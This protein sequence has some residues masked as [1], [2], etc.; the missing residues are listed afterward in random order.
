[1][2]SIDLMVAVNEQ[3]NGQKKN[4]VNASACNANWYIVHVTVLI[5]IT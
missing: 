2:V 4:E 3:Y 5:Q 1:M